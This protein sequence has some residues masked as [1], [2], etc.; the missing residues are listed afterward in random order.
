MGCIH[1]QSRLMCS[2][3]GFV[4]RGHARASV[5]MD[6]SLYWVVM[7]KTR[8]VLESLRRLFDVTEDRIIYLSKEVVSLL[9]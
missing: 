1:E 6:P 3:L 9:C 5:R 4:P 7:V 8:F 2:W